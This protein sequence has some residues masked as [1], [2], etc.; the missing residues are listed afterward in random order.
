V[1]EIEGLI[2]SGAVRSVDV[3]RDEL[4]R[5][6]DATREWAAPQ[7]D[8]FLQLDADVQ[9]ATRAVLRDHPKMMGRGG[10]RNEADPFVVA[11]PSHATASS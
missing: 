6:D 4:K 1:D 5:K 11:W 8:L 2:A 9:A 3:V 10:G 7:A